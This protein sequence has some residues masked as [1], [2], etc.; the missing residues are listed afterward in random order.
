MQRLAVSSASQDYMKGWNDCADKANATIEELLERNA[1]L[2]SNCAKL[3]DAWNDMRKE[4]DEALD[5]E[6][7]RITHLF[8]ACVS[9]GEEWGDALAA[10]VMELEAQVEAAGAVCL[11]LNAEK[12]R[13]KRA[14]ER[15]ATRSMSMYA[16][17]GDMTVDLIRIASETLSKPPIGL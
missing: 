13:F 14:L 1:L 10:R 17:R 15:I 8:G 7:K 3:N 2:A 5:T 9:K 6:R 16:S 11:N 12:L 4:R